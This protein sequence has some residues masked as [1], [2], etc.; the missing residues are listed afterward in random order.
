MS[1]T[2]FLSKAGLVTVLLSIQISLSGAANASSPMG[3]SKFVSEEASQAAE[4][5]VKRDGYTCP[6]GSHPDEKGWWWG[7]VEDEPEKKKKEPIKIGPAG[8]TAEQKEELCKTPETW[9]AQECGFIH[10][11][12]IKDYKKAFDFQ[13]KQQEELSKWMVMEPENNKAVKE[14]QKYTK[15]WMRQSVMA[16]RTWKY[17][18]I[19][20][21]SLD[22]RV[23]NPVSAYGLRLA[24]DVR[25]KDKEGVFEV[26]KEEG[27][28][29]TW[30]TRSD[31]SYCHSSKKII[32]KVK[33]QTKLDVY[34]ISLDDKCM[35]GYE[36]EFCRT[37]DDQIHVVAGQLGVKVVPTL[38][39]YIP[40]DPEDE[41]AGGSWLK[42]ANGVETVTTIVNRTYTYMKAYKSAIA[43]GLKSALQNQPAMDWEYD[44]PTGVMEVDPNQ[45]DSGK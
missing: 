6:A 10:P 14:Y 38:L 11:S 27:A 20:D 44:K 31:C 2:T 1:K 28:F 5:I 26:L 4:Q 29:F 37:Y 43:K 41:S 25:A 21:P 19:Q 45:K 3:Q 33:L 35:E 8:P 30:F 16:T 18:M 39:M 12:K 34:N 22:P 36:G 42:V 24:T 15:W 23:K 32:D 17:N 13:K 40:N 9:D 7:C